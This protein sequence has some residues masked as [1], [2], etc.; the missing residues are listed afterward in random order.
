MNLHT[1]P[2]K[3][4]EGRHFTGTVNG[5][6]VGGQIKEVKTNYKGWLMVEGP[7]GTALAF[8]PRTRA[9][10]SHDGNDIVITNGPTATYRVE[11]VGG[12]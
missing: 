6:R 1:L 2:K 5:V 9:E 10:W 7:H 11:G 4:V 3:L 8:P 12:K